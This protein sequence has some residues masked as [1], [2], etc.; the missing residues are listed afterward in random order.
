MFIFYFAWE[1]WVTLYFK[2]PANLLFT[3]TQ[4]VLKTTTY[5]SN[6]FCFYL[7]LCHSS[8]RSEKPFTFSV[9]LFYLSCLSFFFLILIP[10][11]SYTLQVTDRRSVTSS[12]VWRQASSEKAP[13]SLTCPEWRETKGHCGLSNWQLPPPLSLSLLSLTPHSL[14]LGHHGRLWL[15][16]N[17]STLQIC[18]Y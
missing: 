3:K 2:C 7:T 1:L 9:P 13:L 6:Q 16:I 8:R 14:L 4:N 15:L 11:L 12:L 10:P 17:S 5:Q 18:N